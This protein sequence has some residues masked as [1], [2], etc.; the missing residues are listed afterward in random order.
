M[1]YSSS[2]ARRS[3]PNE[4]EPLA[5]AVAALTPAKQ[6]RFLRRLRDLGVIDRQPRDIEALRERV[7]GLPLRERWR[8]FD[9]MIGRLELE[10]VNMKVSERRWSPCPNEERDARWTRLHDD[11]LS[12]AEIAHAHHATRTTVAKAV[13]RFRKKRDSE[14]MSTAHAG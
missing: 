4:V 3:A 5:S 7:L 8:F 13:Q 10:A 9:G 2:T 1:A 11:G 14:S 6:Q 12:Y